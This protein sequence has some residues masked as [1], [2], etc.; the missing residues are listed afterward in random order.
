MGLTSKVQ[1]SARGE[2]IEQR[3][4]DGDAAKTCQHAPSI[5]TT[6]YCVIN[7]QRYRVGDYIA[8]GPDQMIRVAA[9]KDGFVIFS[10]DHYKFKMH[11]ILAP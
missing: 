2:R 5:D 1:Q 8:V 6:P 7:K 10:G 11:L 4:R 3:Q 9:I